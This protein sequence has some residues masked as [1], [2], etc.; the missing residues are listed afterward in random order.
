QTEES[1]MTSIR[2]G[3]VVFLN[4]IVKIIIYFRLTSRIVHVFVSREILGQS[5][6]KSGAQENG[7]SHPPHEPKK[8]MKSKCHDTQKPHNENLF[9]NGNFGEQEI[10]VGDTKQ[11][12]HNRA[13]SRNL[14]KKEIEDAKHAPYEELSLLEEEPEAREEDEP[15]E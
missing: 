12:H 5:A 14:E 7:R 11:R 3:A 6:R 15:Q 2:G 10:E 4:D 1:G 9:H 13:G 8:R